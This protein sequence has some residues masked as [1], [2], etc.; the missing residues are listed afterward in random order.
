MWHH[1][2][3]LQY[4]QNPTTKPCS[5]QTGLAFVVDG[6]ESRADSGSGTRFRAA[7][8]MELSLISNRRWSRALGGALLRNWVLSAAMGLGVVTSACGAVFPELTPPIRQPPPGFVLEPAPPPDLLYIEFEK[9]T[10][11]AKTRDGRAWDSV[12]GSL[13]DP[14]A[15]LIV[16][17]TELIVTPVQ[18]NTLTP[19]W[20]NQKRGNYRIR[21]GARLRVELWD[22]NPLNNRPIC[23]QDVRD[24]HNN[25]SDSGSLDVMCDSGAYVKILA[26][27]AH[28]KLG[29]GFSYEIRTDDVFVAR[30]WAESPAARAGIKRGD[31]VVSIMGNPVKG[32]PEGRV[33]SLI[34]SNGASGLALRVRGIDKQERDVVIKD[35]PIYPLISEDTP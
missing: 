32:M 16:D 1:A 13:P 20:P 18:S 30:V 22:S 23:R 15:K 4:S 29:L 31:Q 9:A 10:I 5:Q 12:G 24:L 34:N 26:Q 11:P 8:R 25:L 27:P 33:R 14:L 35:G 7:V 17:D 3:A 6:R 21:E 19:T 28:G 2:L